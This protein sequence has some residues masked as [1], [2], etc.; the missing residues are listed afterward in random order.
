MQR[1]TMVRY[2]TNPEDTEENE[3]LSRAVFEEVRTHAP[4]GVAY[5]VYRQGDEWVH[6]F[7]NLRDDNSDAV[8]ELPS[9]KA[10]QAD[11]RAR[12]ATPPE[13]QRLS[14]QLLESYGL[15]G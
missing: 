3:R 9:F 8:T 11:L 7:A 1:L 4:E 12:C 10:Y 15:P 13:P 2:T 6:L 5:A 14:I